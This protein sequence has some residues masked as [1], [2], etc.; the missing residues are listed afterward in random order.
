[1]AAAANAQ[2]VGG[3]GYF[4]FIE[5][6]VGHVGIGMLAGVD[7]CFA[8]AALRES[9]GNH[10]GFDELRAGADDS[11]DC[12]HF[13]RC[14]LSCFLGCV[15]RRAEVQFTAVLFVPQQTFPPTPPRQIRSNGCR[16]NRRAGPRGCRCS[17]GCRTDGAA[18]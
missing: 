8:D 17:A 12:C 11:G 14:V 6:H 5:K 18:G 9:A 1:M 15:V 7:E 16:R 2:V 13:V 3:A 4:E 10:G